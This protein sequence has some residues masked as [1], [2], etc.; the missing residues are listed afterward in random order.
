MWWR[1]DSVQIRQNYQPRN[2]AKTLYYLN[3]NYW[4][5]GLIPLYLNE[6]LF[7]Q[8]A[9]AIM[10]DTQMRQY[11]F[12]SRIGAFSVNLDNPRSAIITLRYALESLKQDDASLYVYPEG[13][14]VPIAPQT[15]EF[16]NGLAWIIEQ[17]Q[18]IDI[19]PV[20]INIDYSHSSKPTLNIL[21]G[22]ELEI[23]N[24]LNRNELTN[25]LKQELNS[26]LHKLRA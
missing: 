4:W 11:R 14:I 12:F 25:H 3:H 26:T 16:K 18:N 24:S 20:G 9:R 19:V 10:E 21:V 1:F 15:A 6:K 5:D 2:G 7:H 22:K 17:K 23:P 13:K 8:R